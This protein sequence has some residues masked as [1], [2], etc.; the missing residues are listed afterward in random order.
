MKQQTRWILLGVAGCIG[1]V[2]FAFCCGGCYLHFTSED[3]PE[4]EAA[5]EIVLPE[6][7][8]DDEAAIGFSNVEDAVDKLV[9]GTTEQRAVASRY[10]A[11]VE[12]DPQHKDRVVAGL[13]EALKE[14][15]SAP[16]ALQALPI[17]GDEKCNPAVIEALRENTIQVTPA[18][19]FLA[20]FPDAKHASVV[21]SY[22][23]SRELEATAAKNALSA[24]GPEAAPAIRRQLHSR[25]P[26]TVANARE[27]L[28]SI[29]ETGDDVL[30]EIKTKQLL[31]DDLYRAL[32]AA[33]W[34]AKEPVV[35]ARQAEVSRALDFGLQH[36]DAEVRQESLN[37]LLVWA[38]P[39]VAPRV[40]SILQSD[41]SEASTCLRILGKLKYLPAA[42]ECARRLDEV[43]QGEAAT[44]ALLEIGPKALPSVEPYFNHPQTQAR[45]RARK[46]VEAYGVKN[47][48]LL[49]VVLTDL[50]RADEIS[51]PAAIDWL[52]SNKLD[53]GQQKK[54]AEALMQLADSKDKDVA[55]TSM[56]ALIRWQH[57][58]VVE[59]LEK[60]LADQTTK[61]WMQLL[62]YKTGAN[63]EFI[64]LELL[65][66]ENVEA[67]Q[68]AC[69]V[70]GELGGPKSV[71]PLESAAK[72]LP[73]VAPAANAA[74]AKIREGA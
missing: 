63:G 59:P 71:E 36:E 72:R 12:F 50:K 3:V 68:A 29:D 20:K 2:C 67:I 8:F 57:L 47:D 74:I 62:I 7:S 64:L 11:S 23:E 39:S 48:R 51:V 70:L 1:A 16:A 61:Q 55:G 54:A 44:E 38:E 6:G 5:P 26:D 58:P 17:W 43:K 73:K 52:V 18:L 46:I 69:Q 60:Y 24:M 45:S 15:E 65:K 25:N 42:A 31:G 28:K 41:P 14:K 27:L 32:A 4:D 40:R 37:A 49:D 35:A 66:N 9:T 56:L 10:L 34:F 30:F 53:A 19:K 21:A 22:L 33:K 13:S